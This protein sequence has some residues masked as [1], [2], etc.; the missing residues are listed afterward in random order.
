MPLLMFLCAALAL[1][2]GA[3]TAALICFVL[4]IF[5]LGASRR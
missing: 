5:F 3:G 1:A 4:G 2:N